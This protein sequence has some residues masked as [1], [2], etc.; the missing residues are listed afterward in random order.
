MNPA[1]PATRFVVRAACAAALVLLCAAPPGSAQRLDTGRLDAL[2]QPEIERFMLEG[3]IPSATIALVAGDE[4]IWTGAYGQ[5]NLWARTPAVPSTVYLIGSTFKAMATVALLQLHEQGRFQLDDP[6][7][8][9]IPALRIRGEDPRRPVTFRHLL[10]HTSGM[11]VDFGGHPVWGPSSPLPLAVYLADSLRVIGPPLDSVRYSNMAYS[12]VGYLVETISGMPFREYM[13]KHVF[14]PLGMRSTAVEPT[15]SMDERLATPYALD[16]QG[17]HV[18]AVRLKANVW[19]AGLVY[20][21]VL[22]QANWL[23]AN[24]NGGVFRGER[25][26]GEALMQ[27][28][29]TVQFPEFAEASADFDGALVGFGLTWRVTQRNGERL[30]AHTGSVAGYTAILVGNLDRRTGIAV[31]TNGHRAHPHLYR[32]SNRVLDILNA[33]VATAQAAK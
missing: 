4:V 14:D 3:R 24:L 19:P 25:V 6:V 23:I 9:Y 30:F 12:L 27:Q 5:S 22:D 8:R 28:M 18:P 20:G 33:Q 26:I 32:L 2:L 16:D 15:P 7:N 10:T 29:H 21:T 11:P 13:Q 1:P 31:L 17:R